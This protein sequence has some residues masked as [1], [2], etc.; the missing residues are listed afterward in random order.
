MLLVLSI[1]VV[2]LLEASSHDAFNMVTCPLK[3]FG[4][5]CGVWSVNCHQLTTSENYNV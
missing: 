4:A 5:L 1:M 2:R 3:C